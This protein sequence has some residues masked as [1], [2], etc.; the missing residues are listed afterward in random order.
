M[1]PLAVLARGYAI[2]TTASGRAIRAASEVRAG[3]SVSI[4]VHRGSFSAKVE[5]AAVEEA[6]GAG[7]VREERT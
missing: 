2:A 4:R 6:S 7:M 3:E 5:G 1:S